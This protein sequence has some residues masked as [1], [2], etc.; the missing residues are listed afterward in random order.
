MM[1]AMTVRRS[2]KGPF[3]GLR[4]FARQTVA[5]V[6]LGACLL[7]A[8]A[9]AAIAVQGNAVARDATGLRGEIAKLEGDV[10]R[11]QAAV[12]ERQ[13]DG[14]VVEKS[15]DLGFVRPGEALIAVQREAERAVE[16]TVAA[17]PSRI[18]KWWSVFVK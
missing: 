5:A 18:A 4:R 7:L 12:V 6:V 3:S 10:S 1:C 9:F 2:K 15:R 16:Q 13:T 17:Q 14:Y 8:A 11:K